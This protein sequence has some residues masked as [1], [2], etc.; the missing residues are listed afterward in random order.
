MA[1]VRSISVGTQGPSLPPGTAT[2][3]RA[4]VAAFM[5]RHPSADAQPGRR[6][7]DHSIMASSL[8]TVFQL[9]AVATVA[10]IRLPLN[11]F[12]SLLSMMPSGIHR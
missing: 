5:V 7:V 9:R 4:G 6:G 3:A 1:S 10:P 8:V 11:T 2:T 12:A